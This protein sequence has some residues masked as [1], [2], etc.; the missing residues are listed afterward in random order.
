MIHA[1]DAAAQLFIGLGFLFAAVAALFLLYRIRRVK[2]FR[3]GA[4]GV[5]V[6]PADSTFP[7]VPPLPIL[8]KPIW[9]RRGAGEAEVALYRDGERLTYSFTGHLS[10]SA[11]DPENFAAAAD[12]GRELLTRQYAQVALC[13]FEAPPSILLRQIQGA[14]A[15]GMRLRLLLLRQHVAIVSL[16]ALRRLGAEVE[17]H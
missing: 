13:S 10:W 15:A 2:S 4:A 17:V 1:L 7:N 3:I 6:E 5:E 9:R 8:Q 14:L 16:E 11:P 12:F